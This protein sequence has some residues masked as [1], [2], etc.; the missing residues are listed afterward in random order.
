MTSQNL[1][2]KGGLGEMTLRERED[3]WQKH[4]IAAL[5][6]ALG[7]WIAVTAALLSASANGL[8]DS[9]EVHTIPGWPIPSW[10]IG[11]P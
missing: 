7:L 2:D 9:F 10:P 11:W 1:L 5:W 6:V 3:K 4:V 8:L